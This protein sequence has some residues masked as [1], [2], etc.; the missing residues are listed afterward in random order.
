[1]LRYGVFGGSFDPIHNGH[2]I[3]IQEMIEV[4]SLDRLFLVPAARSPHKPQGTSLPES[5]RLDA[6]R[7]ATTDLPRVMIEDCELKREPPSYTISTL[8]HLD[9]L[10]PDAAWYLILG[11][12]S[13]IDFPQWKDAPEIARRC[14][15]ALAT[16]PGTA[17]DRRSLA[18]SLPHAK[19]VEVPTTPCGVSSTL[20]RARWRAGLSLRGYVPS[21]VESLLRASRL[22]GQ[23]L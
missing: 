11:A 14:T 22:G 5:V 13:L 3:V 7:A 4:L 19:I 12:D 15:L 1:M 17:I 20:I 23:R 9:R 8:H 10:H 2:L 16:R 18:T 21:E 6:I